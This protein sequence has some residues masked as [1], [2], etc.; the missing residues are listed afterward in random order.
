[1]RRSLND[2]ASRGLPGDH[3]G[4]ALAPA[5]HRVPRR[6]VNAPSRP[7]LEAPTSKPQTR[8]LK[9]NSKGRLRGAEPTLR[10]FAGP[11]ASK[12][13]LMK[14]LLKAELPGLAPKHRGKVRDLFEVEG[15]LL[16]VATDR[17]SAFD[18]VMAEG[19]PHKGRVLT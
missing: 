13:S 8:R 11:T 15:G 2:A 19:V 3:H 17:I 18:V 16:L 9:F 14:P 4:G 6:E 10:A 7:H 1:R 12:A 5:V